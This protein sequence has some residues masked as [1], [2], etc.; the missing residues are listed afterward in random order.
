MTVRFPEI[1][2]QNSVM[3]DLLQYLELIAP[4]GQPVLILGET[5]VGKELFARALHDASGR[6]GLF[7]AVNVAGLDDHMFSDTL[8]GHVKGTYT[9][10]DSDRE[11]LVSR[12]AGGTLFLDEIGDLAEPAQI[13]LLR[14]VQEQEYYRLGCDTPSRSD[15]RIVIATNRDLRRAMNDGRFRKDLYYRLFAHQIPVPPLR[16]RPDDI[17]LLLDSFVRYAAQSLGREVPSY[18][19]ELITLLGSYSFPGNV[20]EFQ[21]MVF[22]AVARSGG[23]KISLDLFKEIILRERS[24][25][26][27]AQGGA[28][29]PEVP[30]VIAF[31]RF[32]TLKEAEDLLIAQALALAKSNQGVAAAMLG[33]SRQA[34]NRRLQPKDK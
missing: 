15:A 16:S 29:R 6:D 21:A 11:G 3:G 22:E 1:I 18:H 34:L 2:T 26:L 5:G 14:L 4:S 25:A 32:P 20:R 17:P 31:S 10:A 8:F 27:P 9:G 24:D 23:G 33:I 13:R 19:P 12:A 7:I 30:P 28:G